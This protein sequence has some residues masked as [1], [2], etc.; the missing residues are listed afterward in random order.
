MIELFLFSLS[1][2]ILKPVFVHFSVF[3]AWKHLHRQS[4][5]SCYEA[6]WLYQVCFSVKIIINILQKKYINIICFKKYL[7]RINILEVVVFEWAYINYIKR[8]ILHKNQLWVCNVHINHRN[9]QEATPLLS[10]IHYVNVVWQTSY[11]HSDCVI[12]THHTPLDIWIYLFIYLFT[13][14]HCIITAAKSPL[15]IQQEAKTHAECRLTGILLFFKHFCWQKLIITHN[16]K[17]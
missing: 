3:P 16:Q 17:R 8:Q 14:S 2:V 12:W 5:L 9:N 13:F 10:I 15:N 1:S 6:N 11:N 7:H 4:K